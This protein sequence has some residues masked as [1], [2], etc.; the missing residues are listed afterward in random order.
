MSELDL[1]AAAEEQEPRFCATCAYCLAAMSGGHYCDLSKKDAR[2]E[3]PAC[4]PGYAR[5]ES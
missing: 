4:D 5:R 3:D 2:P 1:F